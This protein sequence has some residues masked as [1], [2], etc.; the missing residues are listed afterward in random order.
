MAGSGTFKHLPYEAL[1]R[2]IICMLFPIAAIAQDT[3]YWTL[4]P[5]S[6]SALMS[7]AVIGGT[8]DNTAVFYNPAS[9]GFIDTAS[10]SVNAS[11]YRFDKIHIENAVGERRDFKSS[12]FSNFP[13]LLSGT[14]NTRNP[15]GRSAMGYPP[16]WISISKP[17]PGS[18]PRFL[19]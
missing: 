15:G 13:L 18:R 19:S 4:M 11:L 16:T 12:H 8:R 5:G 2:L 17:P 7:G 6:R 14:F 9:L 3:Q 1:V 10:V